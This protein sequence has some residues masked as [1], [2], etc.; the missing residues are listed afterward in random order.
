MRFR[1]KQSS[2][3]YEE[4]TNY[5]VLISYHIS[6]N[7]T[8]LTIDNQSLEPVNSALFLGI[9]IDS[10]LVWRNQIDKLAKKISALVCSWCVFEKRWN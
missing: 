10:R 4:S 9:T 6:E 8:S 1:K 5:E 2:F 3:E 7:K